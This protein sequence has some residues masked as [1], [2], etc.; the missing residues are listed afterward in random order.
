MPGNDVM[1]TMVLLFSI[2][3]L[4]CGATGASQ[5]YVSPNGNDQQD[6][7]SEATAWRTAAK[8]NSGKFDAGDSILFERG[9]E[10]H[11]QLVASSDGVDGKPIIYADYGDAT[12]AKPTFWGSDAISAGEITSAGESVYA[13]Q[14]SILPKGK[15]TGSSPITNS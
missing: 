6:G 14:K 7:R 1:R 2:G 3:W 12:A 15:R 10:W 8:V 9:G 5:Y 13:F 11:E 4:G